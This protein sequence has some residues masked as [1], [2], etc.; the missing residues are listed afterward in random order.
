MIAVAR[1]ISHGEAYQKYTT[2]KEGAV[3]VGGD[4]LVTNPKLIVNNNQLDELWEEF[5]E[6]G[7]D[8]VR[9]GKDVTNTIIAIEYSPTSN[10]SAN[11]NSTEWYNHARTLLEEIDSIDHSKARRDPKTGEW[12]RDEHG[13]KVLFPVPHTQ[14]SKS[15]WMAMLH[16]DANSGILHLHITV[17]RFRPDGDLNEVTDIAKRAAIASEHINERNGWTKAMDIRQRHIDEINFVI[18]TIMDKMGDD[19]FDPYYFKKHMENSTYKDYKG[20]RKNYTVTLHRNDQGV[21]DGYSVGRGMS[22]FTALELGQKIKTIPM[23]REKDIKD[24][25]YDV[26]RTMDTPKFDWSKFIELLEAHTYID[27]DGMRKTFKFEGRPDPNGG[28]YNYSVICG[29]KKYNASQIGQNLTAKKIVKE[30]EMEQQKKAPVTRTNDYS[31]RPEQ[32]GGYDW[33]IPVALPDTKIKYADVT[34]YNIVEVVRDKLN[35][36]GIEVSTN[37]LPDNMVLVR[38]V[39]DYLHDAVN[40][41][42]A[43][44]YKDHKFAAEMAWNCARYA[45]IKQKQIDQKKRQE[46]AE[47]K[48]VAVKREPSEG[49]HERT[50]AISKARVTLSEWCDSH[51]AIF[52]DE[53]ECILGLGIGAKCIENGMSPWIDANM[54]SAARE[55]ADEAAEGVSKAALRM[56]QLAGEILI[57]IAVPQ[58]I[59]LGGGGGSHNDLPKKKDDEWNRF[60]ATFGMRQRGKKYGR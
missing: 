26:L 19:G 41:I 30:Y 5:V 8:H 44:N 4:N 33:R 55:L 10:E 20:R 42:N 40:Y 43:V 29:G 34:A 35:E 46:P 47:Q 6:A 52:S 12:I 56:T 60:K 59:S 11:W 21:V 25:I 24:S 32:S 54:E 18:N 31:D 48:P 27:D 13:N 14:L 37:Q 22:T 16:K 58:D 38:S 15:K 53:Q 49:G 50:A 2:Q 39:D 23:N 57:G 36:V 7:R 28:F 1:N 45:A 9:R 3:F 17:S 51:K